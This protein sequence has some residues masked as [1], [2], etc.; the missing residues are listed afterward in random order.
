MSPQSPS[1]LTQLM[2]LLV[3]WLTVLLPMLCALLPAVLFF[4]G[5]QQGRNGLLGRMLQRKLRPADGFHVYHDLEF[6]NDYGECVRIEHLVLG[7]SGVYPIIS[8]RLS[9][10]VLADIDASVPWRRMLHGREQ[11]IP[12]PLA[13]VHGAADLVS[14]SLGVAPACVH[15]LLVVTGVTRLAMPPSRVAVFLSP[16]SACEAVHD[17]LALSFHDE[18]LQALRARLDTA[19]RTERPLSAPLPQASRPSAL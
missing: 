19:Q 5:R 18:Q 11:P 1:Y 7:S 8:T 9:G 15:P 2:P 14:R 13:R 6:E 4:R 10:E 16:K 12:N 17:R 3:S